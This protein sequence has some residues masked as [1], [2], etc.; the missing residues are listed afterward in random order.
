MYSYQ[1]LK[2][3]SQTSLN[4]IF[5]LECDL[6]FLTQ[7][8]IG[9]LSII[10][11]QMYLTMFLFY[12]PVETADSDPGVRGEDH[13]PHTEHLHGPR[14]EPAHLDRR[15]VILRL[16]AG[17]QIERRSLNFKIKYSAGRM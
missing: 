3:I 15:Q 7:S 2:R 12:V 6:R 5:I 9:G 17:P 13:V 16:S 4:K 8:L 11:S 10:C 1:D 14:P